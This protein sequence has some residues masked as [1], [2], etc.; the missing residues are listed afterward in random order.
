MSNSSLINETWSTPTYL[1][2]VHRLTES[3]RT[4]ALNKCIE[5]GISVTGETVIG[6]LTAYSGGGPAA[7]MA[8]GGAVVVGAGVLIAYKMANEKACRDIV[9]NKVKEFVDSLQH[10]R[11]SFDRDSFRRME[12]QTRDFERFERYRS[13]A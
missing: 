7:V 12:R 4:E 3:Q 9:M 2:E 10:E 6:L 11:S 1:P 5:S 13:V 8:G